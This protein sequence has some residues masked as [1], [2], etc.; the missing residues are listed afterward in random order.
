[1]IVVD[2]SVAADAIANRSAVGTKARAALAQDERWL[3][4]D[5]WRTEVFSA[6]RGLYL[7]GKISEVAA[8]SSIRR[9]AVTAVEQ[10]SISPLLAHVWALRHNFSAYDAPYV[11]LAAERNLTLVTG[12]AR[13]AQAAVGQCRVELV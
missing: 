13:L 1:M 2:A 9:L 11:V 12:D 3:V 10:A 6:I 8:E 5:H 4:P 7:G